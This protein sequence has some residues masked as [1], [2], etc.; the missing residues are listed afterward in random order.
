M[1]APRVM[2]LGELRKVPGLEQLENRA[3]TEASP[4][5]H[6]NLTHLS[7]VME[8][9]IEQ[10]SD[11]V[12]NAVGF[13][14]ANSTFV[15]GKDGVIVIDAM[16]AIENLENALL[17][18]REIC[19]YPIAGV[20]YSH[21]HGDH[22]A[23]SPALLHPANPDRIP[24]IAQR[25]LLAEIGR[26]NGFNQPIMAA[27]AN[28]QFGN[29]LPAS[30][31]G[32]VNVGAGPF[33]AFHQRAGLVPPNTL[34]DDRLE[35]E[36]AGVR[37]EIVWVPSEA[38][39]EIVVW[40]PELGVLQSA[41][42]VQG[43]CYP[44]LYT[45]RGDVP[46]PAAQWVASLDVLRR[47]PAEALAKS[48]GRSV[49]G[50]EASRDHLRNYRDVIAWTHDQTVRFMNKGYVR[51]QIVEQMG[52]MPPH[53]RAYETTGIEGYGS[54]AHGSRSIYTWYL[55]F[56]QGEATDFNPAP[57]AERQRR[58]VEAMGGAD[59]VCDL[60]RESMDAGDNPWAIEVLGYL[61]RHDP[62]NGRARQ[63]AAE[64]HRAEG[65]KQGNA[66]WR[67]WY[68]MAAEELAGRVPAATG[69]SPRDVQLGLPLGSLVGG[70]PPRLRAELAWYQ[71]FSLVL[72]IGG[73]EPGEFTAH[74]RR[75]VL[76]IVAGTDP[77]VGTTLRFA[78]KAAFVDYLTGTGLADLQA[79]DH[80]ELVGSAEV[81]NSFA[82]LLD[83]PPSA[84]RILVTLHG[85]AS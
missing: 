60:A 19:E 64:A 67:N 74:L 16:T 85:P 66:T 55:G 82:R 22:W 49:V 34:V 10:V 62:S 23:G 70:L 33:L 25:Q 54:V 39:D 52:Q 80:L 63:L 73:A 20:V 32:R 81:A 13:D 7:A 2:D 79:R 68:L 77:D 9:A 78:D 53:L 24:V 51:D 83:E 72:V 43:E 40:M 71:E 30:P 69:I 12:Y 26:I 50:A 44:N 11:N 59:R 48:H 61:V 29:A 58:Y 14:A 47:F 41:E 84:D 35:I 45:L 42:C 75:G 37:L 15:I 21:S 18:F 8:P 4:H 28:Y 31:L 38:P 17:A 6:P 3:V 27:R 57:Y 56:N 1:W 65:L 36:I 76:E 46:R 5:V